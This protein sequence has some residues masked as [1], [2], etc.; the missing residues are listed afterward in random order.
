MI[1][2]ITYLNLLIIGNNVFVGSNTTLIAPLEIK[3]DSY[4]AAGSTI[5]KNV[6]K[7]SLA[8]GRSKQENKDNYYKKN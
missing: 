6:E 3:D 8:F 2:L 4:I 1:P 7:N 5:T